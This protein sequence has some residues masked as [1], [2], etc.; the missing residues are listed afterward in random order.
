MHAAK[1]ETNSAIN[2]E[3]NSAIHSGATSHEREDGAPLV[4]HAATDH[5]FWG[6]REVMRRIVALYEDIYFGWFDQLY[7]NPFQR[8]IATLPL[9]NVLVRHVSRR[10]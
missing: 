8:P 1:A 7:R 10:P 4:L 9:F 2:S 5:V 3:A 6:G